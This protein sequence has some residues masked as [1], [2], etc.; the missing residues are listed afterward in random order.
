ML[1]PANL[2]GDLPVLS[3]DE[4]FVTPRR[5]AGAHRLHRL[6]QAHEEWVLVLTGAA[7]VIRQ[8]EPALTLRAG[9]HILIPPGKPHRVDWTDPNVP[10]IWLALHI[11]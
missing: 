2:L 3:A 7:E 1:D 4:Q 8:G 5:E 6:S 10:T 9:D 11:G